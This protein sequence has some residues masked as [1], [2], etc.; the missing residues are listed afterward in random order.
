[1][2]AHLCVWHRCACLSGLEEVY[3]CAYFLSWE[4]V[5]SVEGLIFFSP[6]LCVHVLQ[7]DELHGVTLFVCVKAQPGFLFSHTPHCS[8]LV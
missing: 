1:M 3:I 5:H 7:L 2:C 6:P 4:C 8:F